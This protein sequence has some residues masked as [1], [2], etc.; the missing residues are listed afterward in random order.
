MKDTVHFELPSRKKQAPR[1]QSPILIIIG[2]L[3]VAGMSVNIALQLRPPAA[4]PVHDRATL[5]DDAQQKLAL[6]L[7]KQGL[8]TVAADAWQDYLTNAALSDEEAAT[9]W[10][11]VGKLYQDNNAYENAL[12]SYYRSES[13][14]TVDAIA[15]ELSLRVQECLESL[16]KFAALRHEL[17]DRVDIGSDSDQS[18]SGT[19]GDRVV[20]E[21]GP[22]KITAADLD[23]RI[24][25][26]IDAQ[27]SRLAASLPEEERKRQK[28]AMLKQFATP[29]GRQM[30]LNQFIAEDLLYRH[31]RQSKLTDE[32]RVRD[33][34][35]NQERSLLA[36]LMLE[37]ELNDQINITSND[38][39]TYYEAHKDDYLQ[40]ERVRIAHILV[41][42][43]QEAASIRERLA[44]GED[45]AELANELSQD[46]V[47]REKG[48]EIQRW[49]Q[50]TNQEIPEL[51]SAAGALD[52]IFDT[53]NGELVDHDIQADNG[54]HV[55]KVLTHEPQRQKSF[56]EV[57]RDVYAT[58]RAQKEQEVQQTL[59][60][61]LKEQYDVV[62][63][64]TVLVPEKP[65]NAEE[66][67]Q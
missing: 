34:L 55:V 8:Y 50:R 20:A 66:Q 33:L 65:D 60:E 30:F 13:I 53:G 16:G 43:Y 24:E 42:D 39:N 64:Q 52:L 61:S 47:T 7:E 4:A 37:K 29:S 62:I 49:L 1:R 58:L 14:A 32:Q 21:I 6:K 10:Y 36:G 56:D 2:L 41:A 46:K 35:R 51:G 5:P 67:T 59:L 44:S 9:I 18:G 38:L 63:H 3:L 23:R 22:Q 11:R 45:F 25:S 40:P 27:L 15:P 12:T 54:V 19:Q 31:A 26:S 17:A 48:G 57:Q 28:E